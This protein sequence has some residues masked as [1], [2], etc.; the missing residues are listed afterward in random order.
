MIKKSKILIIRKEG[1]SSNSPPFSPKGHKEHKTHA[2][3]QAHG[4]GTFYHKNKYELKVSDILQMRVK[5]AKNRKPMYKIVIV[6]EKK[7]GNAEGS[8]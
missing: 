7:L 3:R 5:Q 6:K 4:L 8:I 1:Q 2:Y